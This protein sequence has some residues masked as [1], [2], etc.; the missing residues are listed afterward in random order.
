MLVLST[1]GL[2]LMF[3]PFWNGLERLLSASLMPFADATTTHFG[4]TTLC[5]NRP[6]V[7]KS[8]LSALCD[9]TVATTNVSRWTLWARDLGRFA[10]KGGA[11]L[12]G[13]FLACPVV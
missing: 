7:K 9:S 12:S 6:W 10:P 1:I 2:R 4:S 13:N 8:G 5:W 11:G 3:P